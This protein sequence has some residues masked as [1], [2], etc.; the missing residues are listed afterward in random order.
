MKTLA[1][2][3][4]Y[5]MKALGMSGHDL[6]KIVGVTQQSIHQITSGETKQPRIILKLASALKVEAAW[7][8]TG[9]GEMIKKN[10]IMGEIDRYSESDP[11]SEDELSIPFLVSRESPQGSGVFKI[12]IQDDIKL[13]RRFKR[14]EQS[15]APESGAYCIAITGNSMSST[16]PEGSTI[17]IDTN[18][19][20]ITDGK[21]YAIDHHGMIKVRYV[22]TLAGGGLRL[23]SANSAEYPDE[24]VYTDFEV[25][26]RAFLAEIE[27]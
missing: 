7:L 19:K 10:Q 9:E 6:A 27:L 17:V 23:K 3:I 18:I 24:N 22:Y 12:Q 5:R 20:T 26:G 13:N 25:I 8:S 11:L 14:K 21:I 2:R 16:L 1:D 15:R 4:N